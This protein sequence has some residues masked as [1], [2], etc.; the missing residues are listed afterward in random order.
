ML[1]PDGIAVVA[2]ATIESV[3][4]LV[5]PAASTLDCDRREICRG[6][7]QLTRLRIQR[8]MMSESKDAQDRFRTAPRDRERQVAPES[9]TARRGR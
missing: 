7:E 5:K 3:G 9:G 6:L 4:G 2:C 8:A 1:A